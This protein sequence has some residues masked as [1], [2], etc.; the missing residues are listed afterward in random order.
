MD[1]DVDQDRFWFKICL[2]KLVIIVL[3]KLPV[4]DSLVNELY[5]DALKYML[6]NLISRVKS[7]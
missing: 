2:S 7:A 3:E 6:K 1:V 5:P 4:V